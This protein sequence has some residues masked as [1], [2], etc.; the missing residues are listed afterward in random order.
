MKTAEDGDCMWLEERRREVAESSVGGAIRRVLCEGED[1][2][3]HEAVRAKAI[4]SLY[5]TMDTNEESGD[6]PCGY[7]TASW[8]LNGVFHN[9]LCN[10]II[11]RSV[12]E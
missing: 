10:L 2:V 9:E 6:E 5:Q 8:L 1:V 4:G 3:S 11:A 7:D 12:E